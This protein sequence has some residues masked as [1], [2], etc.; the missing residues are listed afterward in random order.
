MSYTQ[1]IEHCHVQTPFP[2]LQDQAC[3]PAPSVGV[4]QEAAGASVGCGRGLGGAVPSA[5]DGRGKQCFNLVRLVTAEK[6]Y[7]VL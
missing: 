3:G 2:Y 1:P 5:G 4:Q 6:A 7:F